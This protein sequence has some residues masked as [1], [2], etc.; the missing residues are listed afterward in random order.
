MR[1]W[2]TGNRDLLNN[3]NENPTAPFKTGGCLD[4][5]LGLDASAQ[6]KRTAPVPGDIRFLVTL[7][8]GRPKALVYRQKMAKPDP[9]RA[10]TFKSPVRE[11]TF[12][13]IDDVSDKVQ[14]AKDNKG[15]YEVSVPLVALGWKIPSKKGQRIKADI[16]VLRAENGHVNARHYWANKAT[17]ITADLPSE[18]ELQPGFWGELE[19]Q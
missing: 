3:S 12:E 18:A 16:G 10:V 17:A 13:Q 7:V 1:V 15:N 14:F 9:A 19:F 2:A 8:D 5:M 4:L 6:A 11:V